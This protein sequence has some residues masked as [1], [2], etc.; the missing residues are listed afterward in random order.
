MISKETFNQNT[1]TSIK[2]LFL[3]DGDSY[4]V[5]SPCI[6]TDNKKLVLQQVYE[7]IDFLDGGDIKQTFIKLLW[8]N[9]R[10]FRFQLIGV[11]IRSGEI[12]M[13][14]HRLNT[15]IP[16]SFVIA[17]LLAFD[18][19]LEKKLLKTI[20]NKDICLDKSDLLEFNF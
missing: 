15:D 6:F 1:S 9:K 2:D 8:V 19:D 4:F 5:Y 20:G 14:S 12:V 3:K 16:C 7:V 10:G 11:D 13:R 17:E 18:E